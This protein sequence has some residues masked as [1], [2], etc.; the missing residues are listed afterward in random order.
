MIPATMAELPP[1]PAFD[2]PALLVPRPGDDGASR[3]HADVQYA[4]IPGYRPLVLDL[5]V[6]ATEGTAVPVVVGIHGGAWLSGTHKTMPDDLTPYRMLW[7]ALLERGIAVATIQYRH[8]REAVFPA[9]IQDVRAAIRWL[10]RAAPALGLDGSR[11]GVIGDSAGGHLALLL[12]TNADVP[13]FDGDFG[14]TDESARVDRVV[15]WYPPTRLDTMQQETAPDSPFS[16][17]AAD[18]PESLLLGV[19]PSEDRERARWAS[20]IS[21]VSNE[22]APTLLVHGTADLV[23][24]FAQSVAHDEALRSAGVPSTLIPVPDADHVF[25]G[26]DPAP[27]VVASADFLAE[28][29]LP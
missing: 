1:P 23:V 5:T 9:Q 17:D 14:V 12:G 20:P 4:Q 6:P 7:P 10:R 8:S 15:A 16:H 25:L 3:V 24:P 19:P 11:I 2:D 13:G 27:I 22:S 18:A 21:Y 29:L 26:A 28:G